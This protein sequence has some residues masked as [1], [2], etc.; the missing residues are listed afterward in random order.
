[1]RD[2]KRVAVIMAGGSGERFWPLSRSLRPKQFLRMDGSGD[3]LLAQAIKAVEPLIPA[4]DIHIAT[5]VA[6]AEATRELVP[7]IPETNYIQIGRASC[8]ERV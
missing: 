4:R 7:L 3:T 6:L 8:R 5:G 2:I 1:M